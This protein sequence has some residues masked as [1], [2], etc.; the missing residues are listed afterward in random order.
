[1]LRHAL[2]GDNIEIV[3]SGFSAIYENVRK[4]YA[5]KSYAVIK[6]KTKIPNLYTARK[7]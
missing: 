4:G 1:M 5:V 6:K 7:E 3:L 2:F